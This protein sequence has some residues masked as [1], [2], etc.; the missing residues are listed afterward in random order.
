MQAFSVVCCSFLTITN[1]TIWNN[2]KTEHAL[3]ALNLVGVFR[4]T[5]ITI[6]KTDYGYLVL[7][8]LNSVAHQNNTLLISNISFE[9][10]HYH[11]QSCSP[12]GDIGL[13]IKMKQDNYNMSIVLSNLSFKAHEM[14][15]IISL[16]LESYQSFNDII[17]KNSFFLYNQ[18]D[19][20]CTNKGYFQSMIKIYL[21]IKNNSVSFV[22]CKFMQNLYTASLIAVIQIPPL[23]KTTRNC[24]EPKSKIIFNNCFYDNNFSPLLYGFGANMLRDTPNCMITVLFT[25]NTFINNTRSQFNHLIHIENMALHFNGN[26]LVY[27]SIATSVIFLESSI[28]TFFP[29]C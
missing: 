10:D 11:E 23:L 19:N 5:D 29:K 8:Y 2:D 16:K 6:P 13:Q 27:S 26:L 20:G 22:S 4:L 25:G 17:I 28:I 3:F 1:I 9:G 7:L 21:P 15:P 18:N 12:G 24:R 14:D